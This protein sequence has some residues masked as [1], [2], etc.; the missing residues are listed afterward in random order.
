MNNLID[1]NSC[2]N[3]GDDIANNWVIISLRNV[4]KGL[5]EVECFMTLT[6]V[7]QVL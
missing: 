6:F 1:W 5:E 4:L 7:M 2:V 3:V